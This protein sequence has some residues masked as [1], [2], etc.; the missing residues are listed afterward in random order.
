MDTSQKLLAVTPVVVDKLD[1]RY[2]KPRPCSDCKQLFDKESFIKSFAGDRKRFRR[3]PYCHT[4]RNRRNNASR[5]KSHYGITLEDYELKARL[6]QNKCMICSEEMSRPCIDHNH[7][8][9]AVRDL[10]CVACNAMIGNA[11]ESLEILDSAKAYL[12]KW[13]VDKP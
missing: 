10:L 13:N 6:Q 9:G 3:S 12:Q 8:T 4:C 1:K 5:I 2:S 11:K 7:S